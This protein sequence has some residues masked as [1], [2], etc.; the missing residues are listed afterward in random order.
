MKREAPFSLFIAPQDLISGWGSGAGTYFSKSIDKPVFS[1]II[2][3]FSSVGLDGR[4]GENKFGRIEHV[5]FSVCV[6]KRS[7]AV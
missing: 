5:S 4:R 3:R 2:Q 7:C 1:A 6:P